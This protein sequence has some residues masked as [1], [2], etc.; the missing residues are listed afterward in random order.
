[1]PGMMTGFL[2]GGSVLVLAYMAHAAERDQQ[3]EGFTYI[4]C[5]WYVLFMTAA[6]DF[7]S[8]GVQVSYPS[9]PVTH[10]PIITLNQSLGPAV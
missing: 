8:M 6:M 2:G 10:V 5:V 1:M 7:D 3:P 4:R 9:Y